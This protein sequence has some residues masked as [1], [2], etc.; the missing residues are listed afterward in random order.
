[1]ILIFDLF[2]TLV[3]DLVM[4]FNLGLKPLWEKHY[5]DKCSFD[6]IKAYGEELYEHMLELHKQGLEFPFVKDELPL[7]AE[8]YGGEV[9]TMNAEKE[10]EFLLRCNKVRTYDG[11]AE[12]LEDFRSSNI[13]MYVLSNSGFR[14]DALKILL[15]EQGIAK[16]FDE[17][18]SSADFGKVKPSTEFFEMAISEILKAHPECTKQDIIFIGDTYQSDVVGAHNA[19]IK[20]AW[21]NRKGETDVNG[22]AA[23]QIKTVTDLMALI[24]RGL[25]NE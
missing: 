13:P 4:D 23:Y 24:E 19:G 8:K 6:E 1:M 22:Y 2:E 7:Y 3:E 12:M 9:L 25:Q 5:Q 20:S 18:W 21:I 16:Y 10:A 14:A 15:E 17:V 11:L